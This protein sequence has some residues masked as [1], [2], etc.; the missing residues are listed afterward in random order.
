MRNRRVFPTCVVEMTQPEPQEETQVKAVLAA[1]FPT[2]RVRRNTQPN[3]N[4][5]RFVQGINVIKESTDG[6]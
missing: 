2:R 5:S 1:V 6:M 3:S 4:N